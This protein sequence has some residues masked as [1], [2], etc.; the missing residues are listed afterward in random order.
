GW[1]TAIGPVLITFLL[2][3]V[4]GVTMLERALLDRREGYRE[5]VERT[6]AFIP[7]FPKPLSAGENSIGK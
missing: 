6:N 4:S 2:L 5:Y 3:R 1:M 7:W